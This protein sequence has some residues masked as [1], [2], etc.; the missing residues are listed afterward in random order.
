MYSH[1][2]FYPHFPSEMVQSTAMT[3]ELMPEEVLCMICDQLSASDHFGSV[4]SLATTSR[5]FSRIATASLH[6][7]VT[8]HREGLGYG[9]LLTRLMR[10]YDTYP[11]RTHCLKHLRLGIV[12][13]YYGACE[14][15]GCILP[16]LSRINMPLP[17]EPGLT[18]VASPYHQPYFNRIVTLDV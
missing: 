16:L 9:Q 8:I 18:N 1:H 13:G 2:I 14:Y 5:N 11:D 4:G 6:K 17:L 15:N 10:T 12:T 3:L 7:T